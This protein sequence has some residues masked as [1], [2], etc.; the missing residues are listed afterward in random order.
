MQNQVSAKVL[1]NATA[2]KK[3][4][5]A[6]IQLQDIETMEIHVYRF[7]EKKYGL[8]SLA[9]EHAAMFLAGLKHF[10]TDQIDVE[11]FYKIFCNE[12]EEGFVKVGRCERRNVLCVYVSVCVN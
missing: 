8:R 1:A 7:M 11:V 6:S 12:I 3:R 9:V 5:T 2:D 4:T 10:S